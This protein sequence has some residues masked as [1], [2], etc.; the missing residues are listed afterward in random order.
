MF[1]PG[2]AERA[3]LAERSSND[4][5]GDGTGGSPG[6]VM[7]RAFDELEASVRQGPHQAACGIDGNQGVPRVCEH[8]HRRFDRGQGTLQLVQLAQQGTLFCEERA[9][10]RA[11]YAVF[12]TPDLPVDVLVRGA[13]GGRS[14][15]RSKASR[16]RAIHGV[17][18]H[19]T[20]AHSGP[21]T[22]WPPTARP[23]LRTNARRAPRA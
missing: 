20:S 16:P 5:L 17:S 11:A 15:C 23:R 6:Q 19:A 4:C 18:F 1:T 3:G 13:A 12:L 10:E 9:P 21:V 14:C 2:R 22:G 7:A 8:E